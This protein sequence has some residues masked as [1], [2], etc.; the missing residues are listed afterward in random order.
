MEGVGGENGGSRRRSGL[1]SK[2]ES[3]ASSTASSPATSSSGIADTKTSVASSETGD[4]KKDSKILVG[5][6]TGG[7]KTLVQVLAGLGV[8]VV[9]TF[10]WVFGYLCLPL[11]IFYFRSGLALGLAIAVAVY[12]LLAN[13][14]R[15][16]G[17]NMT[18]EWPAYRR[19]ITR[20]GQYYHKKCC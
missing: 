6:Y 7:D 12:P 5:G 8:H 14:R 16:G 4:I 11:C 19:A 20:F 18:G 2:E 9:I 17:W 3:T 10:S 15:D 1:L 13:M